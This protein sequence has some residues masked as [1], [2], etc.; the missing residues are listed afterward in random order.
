MAGPGGKSVGRVSVRVLPDTSKFAQEL[1]TKLEKI[2][3]KIQVEAEL[4]PEALKKKAKAAAKKAS[5]EKIEFQADLDS[6]H[7]TREVKNAKQVAQKRTGEVKLTAG[8]DVKKSLVKIWKDIKLINAAAKAYEIK[9]PVDLITWG[10]LIGLAGLFAGTLNSIPT[11]LGAIGGAVNVVGG[12]LAM[13]PALAAGAAAGIAVLV[14]G[15]RG[16]GKALSANDTESLNKALTN[17]APSARESALALREF[18]KPLSE[19]KQATQ[20]ALFKGMADLFRKLK[21]MLPPIKSGMVGIAAGIRNMGS[22]W[23]N[24]ATTPSSIKD[25]GGIMQ[26][27][28]EGFDEARPSASSFGMA[29]RDITVVGSS[30]LPALGDWVSRISLG[31]AEWASKA[32]E[33]GR[34]EEIIQNM[35]DKMKQLGRIISQTFTGFHNVFEALRGGRGS[36]D[37]IEGATSAFANWS[38]L[39]S[40]KTTL[41]SISRVLSE[42]ARVAKDVFGTAWDQLSAAVQAAEPFLL[43]LVRSIGGALKGALLV[44][45]PMVKSL[46]Q[47]FSDNKEV[48]AP[49]ATAIIGLVTAFKLFSTVGGGIESVA[50][51]LKGIWGA[52]KLVWDG[53]GL[54][55]QG[56][57]FLW[58][59]AGD[60]ATWARVVIGH[61]VKVAASATANAIKTAAIWIGQ[62]AKM[63][64][65]T[66]ADLAVAVAAWVAN[67]VRMAAV[68]LAEA[69]QVA[70]AWLIAMGPIA[71]VIAAIVGLVALIIL[72]W[73]TIWSWTKKIFQAI[74]DFIVFIFNTCKD[75]IITAFNAVIDFFKSIPGWIADALS[76]LW[77]VIT[78]PFRKAWDWVVEQW[79]KAVD[80]FTWVK[81]A[82]GD[83]IHKVWDVLSWPFKKAWDIM[84]GIWDAVSGFFQGIVNSI[85]AVIE[86]VWDVLTWP[87]RKAWD[88]IKGIIDKIKG[89]IDAIG[90]AISWFGDV[91]NSLFADQMDVAIAGFEVPMTFADPDVPTIPSI[92]FEPYAG[93]SPVAGQTLSSA[94]SASGRAARTLSKSFSALD[95]VRGT[96]DDFADKVAEALAGWTFQIDRNGLAKLV[97][98]ANTMNARRK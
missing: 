35:I 10:K 80:L 21:K 6:D 95:K 18:K 88:I 60:V 27:I 34:L 87:F 98:K 62:T 44:V 84:K 97:N 46:F 42:V 81:N 52:A 5:G 20:Q 49:I 74:W 9:I 31:F 26:N 68:A 37:I 25:L 78:W 75:A 79:N 72:N 15:L 29:L 48:V 56:A 86:P 67:W 19:I 85:K 3:A 64:A 45:G 7:L 92:G 51:G 41:L 96:K 53:L 69:A 13:L 40:T 22:D 59:F 93:G 24:F 83:A 36:L 33:S 66:I 23:I 58:S 12:M 28:R 76:T 38:A 61:W 43:E 32:R 73:D 39:E 8:L 50:K 54:I 77:D 57:K 55:K 14:V 1:R 11:I 94:S 17:L 90:D 4:D 63:A 70:L 82:V 65:K 91:V 30:F 2:N 89:A 71:L 47:F 16:M